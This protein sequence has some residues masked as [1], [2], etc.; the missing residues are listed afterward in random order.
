MPYWKPGLLTEEEAWQVTAFLLR[1][2]NLWEAS[3]ELTA[4]N[5]PGVIIPRG[6]F[7]TPAVPPAQMDVREAEL[8]P[9]IWAG[10]GAA[11]LLLILGALILWNKRRARSRAE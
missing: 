10:P 5:A 8:G 2:N 4:S 11:L 7:L 6:A 3:T 9:W 1:E